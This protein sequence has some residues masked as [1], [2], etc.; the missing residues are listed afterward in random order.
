[1]TFILIA[2]VTQGPRG[3]EMDQRKALKLFDFSYIYK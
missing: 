1:M 2:S 3:F